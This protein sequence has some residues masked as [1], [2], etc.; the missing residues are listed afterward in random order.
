M[1]KYAKS[2][3]GNKQIQELKSQCEMNSLDKS[4]DRQ[5]DYSSLGPMAFGASVGFAITNCN[6]WK[7]KNG[8]T[9]K[10]W[11]YLT[12]MTTGAIIGKM[13]F[14][15]WRRPKALTVTSSNSAF[16]QRLRSVTGRGLCHSCG[17]HSTSAEWSN[18]N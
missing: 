2:L 8:I 7:S 9:L 15:Q 11:P 16:A 18:C 10:T 6:Q 17:E 5:C 12:L 14:E 13:Y 4:I 3:F 1:A